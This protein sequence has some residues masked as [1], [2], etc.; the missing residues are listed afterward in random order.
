MS[1]VLTEEAERP[2]KSGVAATLVSNHRSFLTFLNRRVGSCSLAEDLLHDAFV[3]ALGRLDELRQ[4]ESAVAW[5]YRILRNTVVDHFRRQ[6][7]R[8][9]MVER[10]ARESE[11]IAAP[12]TGTKK[13]I[14]PCIK[15]IASTLKPEYA[16]ALRRIEVDGLSVQQFARE[17]GITA[18]NAAVRVFRARD[19]LRKRVMASCSTATAYGCLNCTCA[20]G[21]GTCK[22]AA[23]PSTSRSRSALPGSS[24]KGLCAAHP[25]HGSDAARAS[26]LRGQVLGD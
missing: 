20:S 14:C 16:E 26:D 17:N 9:R 11:Q 19:A 25:G 8:E 18:N 10:A 13:S 22:Y 24:T 7:A 12:D 21:K 15:R 2:R 23:A 4:G 5:F 3:K 1:R 6:G